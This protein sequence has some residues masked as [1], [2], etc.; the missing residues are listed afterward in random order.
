MSHMLGLYPLA[1]FTPDTPELFEAARKTIVRRL[2]NGGGQT[3]WSRAWI[4]SFFARLLDGETAYKHVLTLLRKS[5]LTNLFD[6]HPPFQIDGNFGGTA[7]IAEMLLQS[8][9][10]YLRLLPALPKAWANGQVQGLVARGGFEVGMT[11]REGRIER[12]EILSKKG[13]RLRLANPFLGRGR[14]IVVEGASLE[15]DAFAR[16]IVELRTR[17]DQQ[18][19]LSVR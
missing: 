10:G 5:T 4:V 9:Q 18:L 12:V 7:G 3:G 1:Q 2:A 8:H 17:P 15:E 11:W 6:T 16:E 14:E 19:I 13:T